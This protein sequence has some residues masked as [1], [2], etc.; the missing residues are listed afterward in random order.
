MLATL[1]RLGVDRSARLAPA[2]GAPPPDLDRLRRDAQ[3]Q[4][5]V[6]LGLVLVIVGTSS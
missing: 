3:R 4:M 1:A 2:S 6:H 5:T